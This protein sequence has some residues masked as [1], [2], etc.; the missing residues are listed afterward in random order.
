[1]KKK[2]TK[3]N[4]DNSV[5][6]KLSQLK[7]YGDKNGCDA[8]LLLDGTIKKYMGERWNIVAIYKINIRKIYKF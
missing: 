6:D 1:M 7:K 8:V 2:I 3:A 4:V 5:E